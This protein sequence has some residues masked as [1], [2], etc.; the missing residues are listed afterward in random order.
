MVWKAGWSWIWEL[1]GGMLQ[2]AEK[3]AFQCVLPGCRGSE[4]GTGSMNIQIHGSSTYM[5]SELPALQFS[6]VQMVPNGL[7]TEEH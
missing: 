4:C 5:S 3:A 1:G 6:K 2:I 7:K